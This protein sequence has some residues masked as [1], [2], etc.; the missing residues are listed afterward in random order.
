MMRII[1]RIASRLSSSR[2]DRSE[3]QRGPLARMLE[4]DVNNLNCLAQ[5]LA[6]GGRRDPE[7]EPTTGAHRRA[8][9][10]MTSAWFSHDPMLA[11][12]SPVQS[13]E[14]LESGLSL[15]EKFMGLRSDAA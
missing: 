13:E 1:G 11:P 2:E 9:A 7:R 10:E 6:A 3:R 14:T 15:V 8:P 5:A 4:D 12:N